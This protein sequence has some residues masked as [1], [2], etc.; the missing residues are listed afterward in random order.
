MCG[1]CVWGTGVLLSSIIK[2]LWT[3][4]WLQQCVEIAFGVYFDV[5][6]TRAAF[7]NFGGQAFYAS[8]AYV[9]HIREYHK[10]YADLGLWHLSSP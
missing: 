8:E 10:G 7:D 6:G 1:A 2:L 9:L 3:V 5:F 4:G